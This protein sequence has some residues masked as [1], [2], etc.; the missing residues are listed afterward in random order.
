M[1]KFQLLL[2]II[3]SILFMSNCLA[4][5]RYQRHHDLSYEEQVKL[6]VAMYKPMAYRQLAPYFSRAGFKQMPDKMALLVFK[7]NK[8]IELWGREGKIWKHIKNF[9][10]FA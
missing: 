8:R 3:S 2:V 9:R 1:R 7:R 5:M 10:V 4:M 6:K